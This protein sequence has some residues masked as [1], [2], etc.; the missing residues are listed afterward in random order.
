MEKLS[1]ASEDLIIEK[2]EEINQEISRYEKYIVELKLKRDT[3]SADV[4]IIKGRREVPIVP[5]GK[6]KP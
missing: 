4:T 5:P 1:Q 3:L 2:V 6:N